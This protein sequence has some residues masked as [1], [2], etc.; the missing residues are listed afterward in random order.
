MGVKPLTGRGLRAP[1]EN[2][3][4]STNG[5]VSGRQYLAKLTFFRWAE[6]CKREGKKE[7]DFL[8]LGRDVNRGRD[9]ERRRRSLVHDRVQPF[10]GTIYLLVVDKQV[11][12]GSESTRSLSAAREILVNKKKILCQQWNEPPCKCIITCPV[13]W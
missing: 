3:F 1:W 6:T 4:V 12:I 10:C 5:R 7:K 13:C 2:R 11:S 9:P 8:L